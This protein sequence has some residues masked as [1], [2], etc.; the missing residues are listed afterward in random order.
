MN[1]KALENNHEI[2]NFLILKQTV[3]NSSELGNE[4]DYD[5]RILTNTTSRCENCPAI[6]VPIWFILIFTGLLGKINGCI[7]LIINA[8]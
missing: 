5:Y 4:G 1:D 7:S 3:Y 8:R 6:F 2:V